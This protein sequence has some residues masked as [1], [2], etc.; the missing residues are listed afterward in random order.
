MFCHLGT[1][2][3]PTWFSA[4]IFA[5]D[6]SVGKK[7]VL[8]LLWWLKTQ[9]RHA[10]P[11]LF[12]HLPWFSLYLQ[13]CPKTENWLMIKHYRWVLQRRW[14]NW[15][16]PSRYGVLLTFFTCY[17]VSNSLLSLCLTGAG[18]NPLNGNSGSNDKVKSRLL[19]ENIG[20]MCLW[21]I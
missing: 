9:E 4:K 17:I 19:S 20:I 5:C 2:W 18:A 8:Q 16:L 21:R 13:H 10:V 11:A 14:N 1:L 15:I 3:L 6:C 12:L 7:N